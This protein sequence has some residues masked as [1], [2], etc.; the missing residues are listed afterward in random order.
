MS[1]RAYAFAALALGFAGAWLLRAP[2]DGA[3]FQVCLG[4]G[5]FLS[6]DS[7]SRRDAASGESGRLLAGRI[8][9]WGAVDDLVVGELSTDEPTAH[10][11]SGYFVLDTASGE[12]A[13]G[14][15]EPQYH[16]DLNTR[17]SRPPELVEVSW[18]Q[19]FSLRCLRPDD[20]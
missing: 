2:A 16:R 12:F 8:E 13:T 10:A 18:G 20:E 1:G 6:R 14:L 15:S 3:E 11:R 17:G 7:L 4:R 19:Q 9:R 5:Y